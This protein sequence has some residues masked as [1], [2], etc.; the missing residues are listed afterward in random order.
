M[1]A[2]EVGLKQLYS[3]CGPPLATTDEVSGWNKLDVDSST[4]AT[5]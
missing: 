4:K 2:I 1:P 5:V 3:A